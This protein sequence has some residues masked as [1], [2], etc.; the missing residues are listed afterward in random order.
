M[1]FMSEKRN[2]SIFN[3]ALAMAFWSLLAMLLMPFGK[4]MASTQ[5]MPDQTDPAVCQGFTLPP[6]S[7]ELNQILAAQQAISAAVFPAGGANYLYCNE[8]TWLPDQELDETK[9][10]HSDQDNPIS[11][12]TYGGD[13]FL[14]YP[15]LVMDLD[16][17]NMNLTQDQ[18][19]WAQDHNI[20]MSMVGGIIETT[21]GQIGFYGLYLGY[22]ASDGSRARILMPYLT[23]DAFDSIYSLYFGAGINKA[24]Y[25]AEITAC[26]Q[27]D[28]DNFNLDVSFCKIDYSV[29]MRSTSDVAGGA[30]I[31]CAIGGAIGTL[32]PPAGLAV[33][34]GC[35]LG[36]VASAQSVF[37]GCAN[38]YDGCM[39]KAWLKLQAAIAKCVASASGAGG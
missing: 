9:E 24:F 37:M 2:R 18:L 12:V 4:A 8:G 11:G 33:G 15:F 20:K 28:L 14:I 22:I 26:F 23:N 13:D 6:A 29:C 7:P 31:V 34:L 39:L 17:M 1:V 3:L 27:D 35:M 38:T 19:Q 5:P 32:F 16:T 10:I 21:L 30:V 36:A 25:N